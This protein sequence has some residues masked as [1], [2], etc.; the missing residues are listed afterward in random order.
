PE[1]NQPH[2][3]FSRLSRPKLHQRPIFSYYRILSTASK[4]LA[5][6]YQSVVEE[7][8]PAESEAVF[9]RLNELVL[10]ATGGKNSIIGTRG[11]DAEKYKV[12]ARRPAGD[13]D[14][15]P[16]VADLALLPAPRS[17]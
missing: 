14:W 6:Q 16:W 4:L 13:S 7:I 5:E 3:N 8:I 9:E 15:R 17:S 2:N 1:P 11:R 12:D 10:L